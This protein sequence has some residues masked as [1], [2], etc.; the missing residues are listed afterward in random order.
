[1]IASKPDPEAAARAEVARRITQTTSRWAQGATLA[2]IRAGF[3]T[4]LAGPVPGRVEPTVLAGMAAAR[5]TPVQS[6]PR[7]CVLFCHGGGF[8]IGSLRSHESLMARLAQASGAELIGFA[9]RLAPEH[10]FPAQIEDALAAYA[11]LR[12]QRGDGARIVI[13]GDSAGGN[14]AFATALAARDKGLVPPAALVLISPWLDLEMRG[15]SYGTRADKDIFS[16]PEALRAMARTYLGRSGDPS[17][18]LASPVNADLAGL[19]PILVHAGDFD[20]TLD[21]ST[22]L[23]RRAK[24]VGVDCTLRI[25]PEMGHHFQVFDDLP[26]AR[27]SIADIGAFIRAQFA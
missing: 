25:W 27:E 9:Y 11:A 8:Q 26:E 19:P 24:Q 15:E 14:L 2:E 18:P 1:M 10:R 5:F 7:G 13:A 3:E 17:V 12:A 20:I 6:Q 23:A 16:K 4:L 22:L 21:D